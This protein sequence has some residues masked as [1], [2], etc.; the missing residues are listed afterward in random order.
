M[1]KVNKFNIKDIVLTKKNKVFAIYK[2]EFDV[3]K[4]EC[5]YFQYKKERRWYEDELK[6]IGKIR[7]DGYT[8]NYCKCGKCTFCMEV[9]IDNWKANQR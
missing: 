1:T 2:I 3:K 4:K 8:E 6:L 9:G 5:V 7:E